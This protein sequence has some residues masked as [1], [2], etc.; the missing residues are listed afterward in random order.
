MTTDDISTCA[1]KVGVGISGTMA[2]YFGEPEY[3]GGIEDPW[4][5]ITTGQ[6]TIRQTVVLNG[7]WIKI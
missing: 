2:T 1:I 7:L 3:Y 6:F 5:I 4:F